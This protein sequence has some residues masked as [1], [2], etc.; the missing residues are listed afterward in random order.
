MRYL[1]KQLG[2]EADVRTTIGD[3]PVHLIGRNVPPRLDF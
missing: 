1:Y 2:T 3:E